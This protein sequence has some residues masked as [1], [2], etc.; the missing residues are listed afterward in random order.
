MLKIK[1]NVKLFLRQ[2]KLYRKMDKSMRY[3]SIMYANCNR[4]SASLRRYPIRGIEVYY[5]A[6]NVILI[7]VKSKILCESIFTCNNFIKA[8][9][10]Q[11]YMQL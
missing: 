6:L 4:L 3:I 11:C 7:C 9:N 2:E 5:C 1:T 10:W 8:A